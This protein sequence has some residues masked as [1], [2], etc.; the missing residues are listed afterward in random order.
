MNAVVRN[1]NLEKTDNLKNKID[2]ESLGI[3][4]SDN[5]YSEDNKVLKEYENSMKLIKGLYKVNHG[6]SILN[7]YLIITILMQTPV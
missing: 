6:T 1:Q 2:L 5:L 3:S 4:R 7:C